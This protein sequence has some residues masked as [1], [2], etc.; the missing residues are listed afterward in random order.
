ME[1]GTLCDAMGATLEP[2][3]RD[4]LAAELV[5]HFEPGALKGFTE[6]STEFE[7]HL[8]GRNGMRVTWK[9]TVPSRRWRTCSFFFGVARA[10]SAAMASG[11][12][13]GMLI[14]YLTSILV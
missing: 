6:R 10:S 3:G 12:T 9:S 5:R 13:I 11:F 14:M 8:E 1:A 4:R 2:H 7:W